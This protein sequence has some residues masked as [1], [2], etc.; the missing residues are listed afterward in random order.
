[1][2]VP[3]NSVRAMSASLDHVDV[4]AG[5]LREPTTDTGDHAVGARAGEP[6]G[7]G[8]GGSGGASGGVKVE[9]MASLLRD[10]FIV[11]GA[12]GGDRG[13]RPSPAGAAQPFQ[14]AGGPIVAASGPNFCVGRV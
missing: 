9:V 6:L 7:R 2:P 5:V 8:A 13:D 4:D 10:A 12:A 14:S 3:T 1:M 11:R